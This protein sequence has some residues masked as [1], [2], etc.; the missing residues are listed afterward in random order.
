MR[1]SDDRVEK[2]ARGAI[3]AVSDSTIAAKRCICSL[4]ILRNS[5]SSRKGRNVLSF[6]GFIR[7]FFGAFVKPFL[8]QDPPRRA[9]PARAELLPYGRH[10]SA[11]VADILAE[12][13]PHGRRDLPD[14]RI[15]G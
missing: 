9:A 8:A 5:D 13:C 14:H 15:A 6:V 2:A 3:G 10:P 4:Q 12:D 11:R 1:I 7:V